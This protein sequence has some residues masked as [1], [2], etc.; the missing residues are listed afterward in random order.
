MTLP[1]FIKKYEGK[2]ADFDLF[3]FMQEFATTTVAFITHSPRFMLG[4]CCATLNTS[5]VVPRPSCQ[6]RIVKMDMVLSCNY[7]KVFYSIVQFVMVFVMNNFIRFQRSAKIIF[8][9]KSMLFNIVTLIE[10]AIKVIKRNVSRLHTFAAFP[11][12]SILRF[13]RLKRTLTFIITKYTLA[14]FMTLVVSKC[15]S[16]LITLKDSF[17]RFVV[18]RP[19][20]KSCFLTRRSLE[21]LIAE[22]TSINHS[23]IL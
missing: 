17:T 23:V 2:Y 6:K 19:I 18:T 14:F 5:V 16:T 11:T 9:Y 3:S 1:D 20:T 13:F 8:H 21:G 12:R 15:L 10:R 4:L 22:A 7:F